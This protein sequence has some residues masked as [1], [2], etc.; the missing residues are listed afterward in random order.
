MNFPETRDYI[1]DKLIEE[2]DPDLAYHSIEHT[3]DVLG[4]AVR[5][6]EMEKISNYETRILETAALFHDSGMITTYIGHEDASVVFV[7]KHLPDFGYEEKDIEL[8][9]NMILTTKLPQS[10]DTHLEKIL[11]DA[12]LDYLGREDFFM[13]AHQLRYEWNILDIRHTTLREWYEL[14]IMFL[15]NHQFFTPSAKALR[16][17]K[18]AENLKQIKELVCFMK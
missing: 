10:A 16:D 5:F 1:I 3:L 12:D 2:L 6:A 11:C 4:A 18:K 17:E 9:S 7:R 15:E 13:I 8:I 14:Q